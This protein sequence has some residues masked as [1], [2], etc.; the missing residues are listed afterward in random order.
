MSADEVAE[1]LKNFPNLP[2]SAFVPTIV[3]ARHDGVSPR[4]VRRTYPLVELSPGRKGVN[5]G[6]LRS[7]H[8]RQAATK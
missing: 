5:V 6:W 8:A 3:A 1:L 2:D 4:T 7:R